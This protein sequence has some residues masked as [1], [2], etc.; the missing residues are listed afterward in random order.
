MMLPCAHRR[1]PQERPPHL[2]V[3]SLLR[4]HKP[5]L[6]GPVKIKLQMDLNFS[7][8]K[9]VI[10]VVNMLVPLGIYCE[11]NSKILERRMLV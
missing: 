8:P 9:I 11:H 4:T 3:A 7:H 10:R 5:L 1:C 6:V 2:L